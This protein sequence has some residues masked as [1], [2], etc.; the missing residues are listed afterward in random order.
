MLPSRG[1]SFLSGSPFWKC[2]HRPT[3][4]CVPSII[5][6]PIKSTI[7]LFHNFC[8][9]VCPPAMLRSYS[10]WLFLSGDPGG[11]LILLE[12]S[13]SFTLCDCGFPHSFA[14]DINLNNKRRSQ[15]LQPHVFRR[16]SVE[17]MLNSNLSDMHKSYVVNCGM[18]QWRKMLMASIAAHLIMLF[19][20]NCPYYRH[21]YN[22][23]IYM[24]MISLNFAYRE[25][26]F[27]QLNILSENNIFSLVIIETFSWHQKNQTID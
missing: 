14:G 5:S 20:K 27:L 2:S 11:L 18:L 1:R 3:Q 23:Y 17:R 25:I 21:Y 16:D 4:R 8:W 9:V 7:L 19:G 13:R 24:K 12:P 10:A 6:E 22:P 15:W 26:D